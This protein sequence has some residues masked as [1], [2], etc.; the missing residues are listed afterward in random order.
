MLLHKSF[1]IAV[2]A[3]VLSWEPSRCS[4]L[5]KENNSDPEPIAEQSKDLW[6]RRYTEEVKLKL[7]KSQQ[8]FVLLRE[9]ER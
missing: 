6:S 2:A 4:F 9:E 7:G 3:C 1:C 5:I 8:G